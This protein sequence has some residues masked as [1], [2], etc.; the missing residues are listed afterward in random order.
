MSVCKCGEQKVNSWVR[1]NVASLFTAFVIS[2]EL[3]PVSAWCGES[4]E[5]STLV[6]EQES[7]NYLS[8]FRVAMTKYPRLNNL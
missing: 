3:L 2:H 6:E 8:L 4:G 5:R 7:G 1:E